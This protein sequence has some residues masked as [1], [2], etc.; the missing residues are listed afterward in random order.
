MPQAVSN[1]PRSPC[2]C[3]FD[4][5]MLCILDAFLFSFER[6]RTTASIRHSYL[7]YYYTSSGLR[8]GFHYLLC[9]FRPSVMYCLSAA[10]ITDAR[11]VRDRFPKTRRVQKR[12]CWANA[13]Y[14]LRRTPSRVGR[15][16]VLSAAGFFPPVFCIRTHT[17]YGMYQTV[18]PIYLSINIINSIL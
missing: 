6:T 4:G 17:T 8:T 11:A 10:Y 3:G 13:W 15:R 16:C 1:W 14:L 12:A 18:L 2:C 5:L 7:L 9:R